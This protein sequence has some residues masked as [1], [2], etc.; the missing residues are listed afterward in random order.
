MFVHLHVSCGRD[1]DHSGSYPCPCSGWQLVGL[2]QHKRE[3]F[4]SKGGFHA[5]AD[6]VPGAG[7]LCAC[8][9]VSKGFVENNWSINRTIILSGHVDWKKLGSTFLAGG[10]A[11]ITCALN[12][13]STTKKQVYQTLTARKLTLG[14]LYSRCKEWEDY[15]L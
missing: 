15:M 14:C 6:F 10:N 1:K 12:C 2:S 3:A 9:R 7:S 11:C 13:R 5:A 4:R 8:V